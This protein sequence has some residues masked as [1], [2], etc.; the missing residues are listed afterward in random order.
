MFATEWKKNQSH[1]DE[2]NLFKADKQ[3]RYIVYSETFGIMLST[4]RAKYKEIESPLKKSHFTF[5]LI[6]IYGMFFLIFLYSIIRI[7]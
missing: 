1:K 7:T 4:D 5:M 3:Y 2:I 6:L